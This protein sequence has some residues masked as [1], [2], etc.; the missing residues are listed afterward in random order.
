MQ[1]YFLGTGAGVPSRNR[2]VSSLAL[3]LPEYHGQIW[4]FDCGEATQH[5][6]WDSPV[7]LNRVERI[8]ITHLHGDHI[9]GL[10]G[11]LGSRSFQ[12]AETPLVLYGP[13]GLKEFVNVALKTSQTYLRYPLQIIE[14]EDGTRLEIPFFF[15]LARKL[16][17]G[18]PSYGYRIEERDQPGSL[19]VE[20]LKKADIPPGPHY[21]LL[22]EGKTITLPDGR[23]VNGREFIGPPKRGRT[24]AI[25][26][27]TRATENSCL[28]AGGC[29]LL[30][31]EATYRAGQE[32]LATNYFHSTCTEAA[33]IAKKA[34]VKH[35]ILNHISSRFQKDEVE[36]LLE[37]ARAIFPETQ[38][39]CD[40]WGFSLP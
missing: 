20:K 11:I 32:E 33:A 21:K 18:I 24:V 28:L 27:D 38:I 31:H 39:A 26:G 40:G 36:L 12:G 3:I 5:K 9:Y 16:D 7:K 30:I 23:T 6:I 14:V 37:E 34:G 13:K 17:H 15:I 22:K 10:P 4:L 25:L 19:K 8:F 1:F 29:D 35:L 2:N